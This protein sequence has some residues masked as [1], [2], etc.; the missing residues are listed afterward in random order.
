M[1][2]TAFVPRDCLFARFPRFLR[3]QSARR[4]NRCS[5]C[6]SQYLWQ[7]DRGFAQGARCGGTVRVLPESQTIP[8]S[9]C[10]FVRSP[11]RLILLLYSWALLRIFLPKRRKC[12]SVEPCC[13]APRR[14]AHDTE[15][16]RSMSGSHLSGIL[17]TTSALFDPTWESKGR[18]NLRGSAGRHL[19]DMSVHEM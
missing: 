3:M 4:K 16:S 15:L 1:Q 8:K 18:W 14:E 10:R 6:F 19:I 2:R 9:P 17:G 11:Q 13:G 7:N 5:S 12:R